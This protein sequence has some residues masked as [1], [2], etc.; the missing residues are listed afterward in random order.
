MD[1]PLERIRTDGGTQPR[2]DLLASLVDDYAEAMA[3]GDRF[4]PVKVFHD[5]T[6]HWLA[7]GFHRHRA[8]TQAGLPVLNAEI[9]QGTQRDAILFS[10]GANRTHGMRRGHED[11]RC[12]IERLLRD[13]EWV[14][15]SDSWLSEYVGCVKETV[16]AHR[17]RLEAGGEIRLLD[18]LLGKDGKWYPRANG[19]KPKPAVPEMVTLDAWKAMGTKDKTAALA[20]DPAGKFNRQDT[21]SIEWA[22][23]SWNPITGCL[24]GCAYC[25][26]RDIAERFYPQGFVPVFHPGRLRIPRGMAVPSDAADNIGLR[27]VFTCSMADL[28]GKW[29]PA[30]WIEA[31]LEEARKAK[32]WNFLFL[33]KFPQR[34]KDFTFPDNAWI[35]TTVD[36][37]SSVER[38]EKAFANVKASVKWLSVEPLLEPLKFNNLGLFQW[39]VI[40]GSSASTQ[41]PEWRPPR[42]WIEELETD[43][44][45][46]GL[47]IYEKANLLVRI[48]D[49]PGLRHADEPAR[50]PE[51]LF[52]TS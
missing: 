16:Q 19:G 48:R 45:T 30:E 49:Y 21:D 43:A 33:T 27:N 4:P 23:W 24:H 18:R 3:R 31:V 39:M 14:T 13:D 51:A 26:A 35:G 52:G 41:T 9:T 5:G 37:Q 29:V 12:A 28:F 34:L 42:R 2:S 36:R 17:T 10:V 47:R 7:D 50:A 8:A 46:S 11:V 15:W 6:D 25:Y 40:G 38:A 32:D 20:S 1:L 22:Q 44:R